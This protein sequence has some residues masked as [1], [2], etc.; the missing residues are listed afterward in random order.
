MT[1]EPIDPETA[2]ELY[3]ADRETELAESSIKRYEYLLNHFVRWCDEREIENLNSLSGRMLQEFRIWRRKDGDINKVTENKQ[4][5]AVRVF[6]GWLE[7]IDGVEQDLRQKV[8]IPTLSAQEGSRD[9]ML[10]EDRAKEI[11]TWLGKYHYAGLEHVTLSLLWH[12]MIRTGSAR[13][14]DIEDYCPVEQYIDLQHRPD[15]GTPLK[16]KG[17]G[18]RLIALSDDMC[19]LLDDW[20]A[21]KHPQTRDK[22]GREPLLATRKGRIARTT[23]KNYVYQWSRPCVIGED[24]PHDRDPDDCEATSRNHYSKC[25]SSVSPHAIRRGSITYGLNN[26]LPD[27]VI[28]DRANVSPGILDKHYDRRTDR[29]KMEQR[30]GYLDNI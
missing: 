29:E 16:N 23:L 12:T 24:C 2:L 15:R 27:Q 17:R 7:S 22:F 3:L 30:R 9:V 6:I 28:S 11:L 10:E 14:I 13:A 4:M 5:K 19:E 20:I 25:P 18:E 21:A 26:D 8:R 1:L